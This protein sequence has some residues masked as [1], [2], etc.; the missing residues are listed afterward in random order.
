[1]KKLILVSLF[2]LVSN[3]FA[4]QALLTK[5]YSIGGNI[6]F[7]SYSEDSDSDNMNYFNFVP[8][9]GYFFVDYL[10]T[11]VR[12]QYSYYSSGDNSRNTFGFAPEVRYY[13]PL[14]KLNP[15][16]GFSYGYSIST[17]EDDDENTNSA[18]TLSGGADYFIHDHFA[19]EGAINYSFLS[20]GYSSNDYSVD[21]NGTNFEIGFG[22][23]YFIF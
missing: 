18:L 19:I 17:T 16:L 5:S 20:R 11:G 13:F 1:M 15:F 10:Y 8:S 2:F 23:K 6:S 14:D 12:L 9:V 21:S 3:L 7:S 22:V 4:Q